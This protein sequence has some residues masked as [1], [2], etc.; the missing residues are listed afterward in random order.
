MLFDR[1]DEVD[2]KFKLGDQILVAFF[3]GTVLH[4]PSEGM[5]DDTIRMI[6]HSEIMAKVE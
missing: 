4:F 6:T 5:S 2:K 3:S 1:G